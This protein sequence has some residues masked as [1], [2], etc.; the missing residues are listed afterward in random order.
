MDIVLAMHD[1]MRAGV[2]EYLASQEFDS[3]GKSIYSF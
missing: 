1:F 2:G 3:R